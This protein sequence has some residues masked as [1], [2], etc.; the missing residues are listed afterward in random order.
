MCI[1]DRETA[2]AEVRPVSID[3]F[4]RFDLVEVPRGLVRLRVLAGGRDVTTD[5]VSL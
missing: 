4:G 5:W 1:R 3:P 2:R